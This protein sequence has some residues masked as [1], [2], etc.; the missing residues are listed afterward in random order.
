MLLPKVPQCVKAQ[1]KDF[2]TKTELTKLGFSFLA[3]F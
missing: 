1:L 2:S 3:T